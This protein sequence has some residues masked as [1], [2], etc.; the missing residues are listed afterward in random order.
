MTLAIGAFLGFLCVAFGAYAE[1]GLK[2]A[3]SPESWNTL[4]IAMRYHQLHALLLT[5]LGLIRLSGGRLAYMPALCWS[6]ACL[7][8]GVAIFCGSLYLA[9]LLPM[10]GLTHA[11]PL[12]GTL[13]M[14]GWLLLAYTGLRAAPVRNR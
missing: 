4:M 7:T 12:G 3:L 6:T 2:P 5:M 13:L 8:A 9:I 11:A 1:H 10:P 14:L